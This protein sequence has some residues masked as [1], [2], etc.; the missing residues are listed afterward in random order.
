[1]ATLVCALRILVVLDA[2]RSRACTQQC[3]PPRAHCWVR[4]E[5]EALRCAAIE[6]QSAVHV[7]SAQAALGRPAAPSPSNPRV[8]PSEFC[9][10]PR[11]TLP[12]LLRGFADFADLPPLLV[13]SRVSASLLCIPATPTRVSYISY[14]LLR[15]RLP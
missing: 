5:E 4:C 6:H 7:S 2:V 14:S 11:C 8:L 13:V 9:R 1:M 12:L 3:V 15:L 10:L